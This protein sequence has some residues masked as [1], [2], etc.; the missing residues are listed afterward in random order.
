MRDL[1]VPGT[2]EVEWWGR[3]AERS[4]AIGSTA[5]SASRPLMKLLTQQ[6]PRDG[7]YGALFDFVLVNDRSEAKTYP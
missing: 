7:Q 6:S 1:A 3:I 5:K 2:R 4:N